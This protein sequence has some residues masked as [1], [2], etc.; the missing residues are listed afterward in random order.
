MRSLNEASQ[1]LPSLPRIYYSKVH[2][3]DI[4]SSH[5]RGIVRSSLFR[6]GEAEVGAVIQVVIASS[7]GR[8]GNLRRTKPMI[9]TSRQVTPAPP[10][11]ILYTTM[12]TEG[13][14][15]TQADGALVTH[16]IREPSVI[17]A[18]DALANRL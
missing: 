10:G 7:H 17:V 13:P 2:S 15:E 9:T 3:D 6:E 16:L 8:K 12:D 18:D 14:Q 11:E 1:S 5:E 4:L